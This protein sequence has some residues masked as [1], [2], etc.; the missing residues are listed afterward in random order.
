MSAIPALSSSVTP[1]SG[2][3]RNRVTEF[4]INGKTM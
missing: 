3:G 2:Y 4:K 1:G